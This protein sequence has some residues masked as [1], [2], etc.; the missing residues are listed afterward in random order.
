VMTDVL[1][2][3]VPQRIE[4]SLI[5]PKD[6]SIPADQV[7]A[8]RDVLKEVGPLLVALA[9]GSRFLFE[10]CHRR[11]F[12]HVWIEGRARSPFGSITIV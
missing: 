12:S 2:L 3:K 1:F 8:E 6:S 7:E 11:P 10:I 5:G 4:F 9:K